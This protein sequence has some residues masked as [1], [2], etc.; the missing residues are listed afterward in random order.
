MRTLLR[1]IFTGNTETYHHPPFIEHRRLL[2]VETYLYFIEPLV[3]EAWRRVSAGSVI[4]TFRN[5]AF[6]CWSFR[7]PLR[8]VQAIID[9]H[10]KNESP[11]L[12]ETRCSIFSRF[13][14]R[15]EE[16]ETSRVAVPPR[17]RNILSYRLLMAFRP[18]LFYPVLATCKWTC[19]KIRILFFPGVSNG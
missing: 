14:S 7:F 2:V 5:V 12:A 6:S 18:S 11:R 16:A 13:A 17:I 8:F 19:T 1:V 9:C 10:Q 3:Q 4:T 15:L